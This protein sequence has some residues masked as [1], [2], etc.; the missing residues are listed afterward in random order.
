M[1]MEWED[2]D[3][4]VKTVPWAKAK[5]TV[6]ADSK[7]R[8]HIT[9]SEPMF[10]DCGNPKRCDVQT[11]SKD[12]KTM[13]RLAFKATGKFEVKEME[14]G[15]ARIGPISIKPPIPDG[16]RDAESCELI[17]KSKDEAVLALPLEDWAKQLDGPKPA[18]LAPLKVAA[19]VP[20]A[21]V[22][23]PKLDSAAYLKTKGLKCS[24]LA[25]NWW[26][27][28]GERVPGID[29]LFRVNGFRRANGLPSLTVDQIE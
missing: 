29:V 17:S 28:E 5:I 26:M 7:V 22:A 1:E 21:E 15:G 27:L 20:R 11:G 14:L 18:N 8:M 25:G 16:A 3:A 4:V 23:T 10:K 19:S 12:G 24:K 13:V 6:N 9:L 2:L